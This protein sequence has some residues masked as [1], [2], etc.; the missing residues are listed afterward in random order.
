MVSASREPVAE[1]DHTRGIRAGIEDVLHLVEGIASFLE[2]DCPAA[3]GVLVFEDA[4]PREQEN[5]LL[6]SE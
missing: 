1:L 6:G 5:R 3:L 4:H 2:D